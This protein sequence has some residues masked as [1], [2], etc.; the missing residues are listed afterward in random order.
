MFNGEFTAI[1]WQRYQRQI[2]TRS[3]GAQG[4]LA[5]KNSTVAIIGIG[6]LGC[7]VAQILAAVG[8]GTLLL[9][10]DDLVS[11]SNLHRQFLFREDDIDC[12]KSETAAK[13]LHDI[14]PFIQAISINQR[15]SANNI[16]EIGQQCDLIIDCTDNMAT[17][18]LINDYCQLKQKSWIF[19]SVEGFAGQISFFSPETACYRC[20]FPNPASQTNNCNDQGI[21]GSIP[22][23]LANIQANEAIKY[24]CGL[25]LAFQNKLFILDA[26]HHKSQLVS[27]THSA[28]CICNT[29][30]SIQLADTTSNICETNQPLEKELTVEEFY[31]MK[32]QEDVTLIDLRSPEEHR[33]LNIG[34]INQPYEAFLGNFIHELN[35]TT[36]LY[37]HSGQR[38]RLVLQQLIPHSQNI[39]ALKG[40]L[41]AYL[42]YIH[43]M[44]QTDKQPTD[45]F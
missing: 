10:D 24:L 37:C 3:F 8:V 6:G 36:I 18:Y 27:L 42:D 13:K 19:G 43:T 1:E 33:A 35:H 40:G 12:S 30:K 9:V 7:P 20:L 41:S 2:Q 25:P 22:S 32:G 11:R 23:L 38:S 44:T 31:K 14:N 15:L 28:N 39:Y 16:T 21:V 29:P 5:L 45:N 26:L 4:Q 34:G 17:R